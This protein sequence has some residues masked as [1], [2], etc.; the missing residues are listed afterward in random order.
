[1]ASDFPPLPPGLIF[2]CY[3]VLVVVVEMGVCL[4]IG[5]IILVRSVFSHCVILIFGGHFLGHAHSP[6][7]SQGGV[8][9][10]AINHI[11]IL[12]SM[13]QSTQVDKDTLVRQRISRG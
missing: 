3:L 9:A 1:M 2:C 4:R 6:S 10:S 8:E 13:V 5:W 12:S 7:G 11:L